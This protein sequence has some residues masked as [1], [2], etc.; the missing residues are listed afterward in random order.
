LALLRSVPR[1]DRPRRARLDPVQGQP[2]DLSRLDGGCAFRPRCS[3]A[4]A[5]CAREKPVLESINHSHVAC[6]ESRTVAGSLEL[7]S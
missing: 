6:F 1:M 4:T 3:F 2:P 7:A 5:R